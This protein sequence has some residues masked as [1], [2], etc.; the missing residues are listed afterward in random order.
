MPALTTKR[1]ATLL[2]EELARDE[3]GDIDLAWLEMVAAGD[4]RPEDA[5][6]GQA[7][8]LAQ[9]IDRVVVRLTEPAHCEA[10][11]L[12]AM[13]P[14]SCRCASCSRMPIGNAP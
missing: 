8:A 14:C 4:F 3:W 10:S 12:C 9:V 13:R 1:L 11:T 2:V 7:A 6:Y 5:G